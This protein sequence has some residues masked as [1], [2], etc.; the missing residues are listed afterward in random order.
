MKSKLLIVINIIFVIT[1]VFLGGYGYYLSS[2]KADN[3][4][5]PNTNIET[6]NENVNYFEKHVCTFSG[7]IIDE[8][9]NETTFLNSKVVVEVDNDN[10][11]S[12][13]I[14]GQIVTYDSFEEYD[15]VI[16]HFKDIDTSFENWEENGKYYIYSYDEV[17]LSN[18]K[19]SY[20]TFVLE[21]LGTSYN[22]QKEN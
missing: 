7:D 5:C 20:E 15:E 14:I 9:T 18:E 2:A 12:K 3:C 17:D 16:K 13:A 11:V 6:K 22:C 8:E 21:H 19:K 4:S 1:F 10:H